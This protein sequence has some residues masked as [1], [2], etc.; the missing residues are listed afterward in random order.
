MRLLWPFVLGLLW[1]LL[2][3]WV[4]VGEA[5]VSLLTLVGVS[6][7]LVSATALA[8][9]AAWAWLRDTF[10]ATASL[11]ERVA[12]FLPNWSGGADAD[13]ANAYWE[14][15]APVLQ[16]ATA[17]A[18]FAIVQFVT[19]MTDD[20]VAKI[21]LLAVALVL[22]GLDLVAGAFGTTDDAP[23]R[24]MRVDVSDDGGKLAA[25]VPLPSVLGGGDSGNGGGRLKF[26]LDL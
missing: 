5:W 22:L 2:F 6:S 12:R 19:E 17:A 8:H 21:V 4:G 1:H 3:V 15:V 26:T 7:L 16:V 11:V 10:S 14:Q 13:F 18:G 25:S 23:S 24:S 9:V 20:V